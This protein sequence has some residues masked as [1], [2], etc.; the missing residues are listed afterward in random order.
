[1]KV[2]RLK[3]EN[4]MRLVAVDITP[5]GNLITIGGK[6]GAGKTS[7]LNSIAMVLG[8]E[9]LV[10]DEPI[11]GDEQQGRVMAD[12]GE[13]VVT[14]RFRRERLSCDCAAGAALQNLVEHTSDCASHKFGA[15]TSTLTVANKEGAKFSS[16]QA[17]LD[18]ILGKLTF[19]PLAFARLSETNEGRKQ[20]DAILRKLVD[21]DTTKI[22]SDRKLA[23]A[24]R[25]VLRS[26]HDLKTAQMEKLPPMHVDVPEVE[27]SFDAITAE[28]LKVEDADK[29]IGEQITVATRTLDQI[30]NVRFG[31]E[32]RIQSKAEQ[33][34]AVDHQIEMLQTQRQSLQS[35][36]DGLQADVNDKTLRVEEAELALESA[37]K[38]VRPD[39][40]AVRQ[41][42]RDAEA[43]NGRIR[44]NA[45]RIAAR[46]E[47][48]NVSSRIDDQEEIIA[49]LDKTKA[50]LLASAKFPVDGLGLDDN[51]V[52][53]N[54]LPFS[55]AGRAEQI[56]V[57]VA[58][59]IALN[60]KLRVLLVR[61]G[62]V[63]D[64]SSL[65]AL[66]AQAEAADAQ[67][68]LEWVA[69]SKED[70]GVQVMIV[71]GSVV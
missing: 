18:K 70:G 38:A 7:V 66:T 15:T 13:F 43:V 26:S 5:E 71:D 52:T 8:G 33:I 49:Y 48:A 54:R 36:L 2:L 56:R 24:E 68:W 3:S 14:R 60:P 23:V 47:I 67:V 10:P 61:D 28:L 57:S 46:D 12:L 69:E 30:R 1:M 29:K 40:E 42:R 59:G 32:T 63:L 37:Q 6:N 16:P 11:H 51:G 50:E 19:D 34:K 65:D 22:D 17:M 58:I 45:K 62:N 4:I 55:Q 53:F 44:E 25:S 41:K 35:D 21:I 27:L 64:Q 31:V 39:V 20:Q 9:R